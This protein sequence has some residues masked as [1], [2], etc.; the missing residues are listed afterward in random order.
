MQTDAVLKSIIQGRITFRYN[1]GNHSSYEIREVFQHYNRYSIIEYLQSH[2]FHSDRVRTWG[3]VAI[4][5]AN[6]L[7]L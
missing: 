4:V 7:F 2:N 5:K 3:R 6:F 1:S